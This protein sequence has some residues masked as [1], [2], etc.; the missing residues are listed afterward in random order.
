MDDK[1]IRDAVLRYITG[2]LTEVE[3]ARRAGI[4]RSRLRQYARTSGIIAPSP[5]EGTDHSE[6]AA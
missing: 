1:E 5:V 6:P 3:A 2:Q 4:P